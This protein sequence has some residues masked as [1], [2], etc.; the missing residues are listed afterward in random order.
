[1]AVWKQVLVAVVLLV[2]AAVGFV[3]FFP[4][5]QALL[6][7]WGL[8]GWGI[9]WAV[10]A[11]PNAEP[12]KAGAPAGEGARRPSTVVAAPVASATINDRL[13]AIGTGRANASVSIK[14]YSSGRLA[15]IVVQP[16]ARIA[17]GEIIARLDSDTE[18]IAVDRARF[19]MDDATA[20]AKRVKSLFSSN[21]ATTVQVTDADLAV[22]NA[23][24]ALGDAQLALERRVIT[25]P[26]GGIVGILPVEAGNYVDTGTEIARV[27]DRSS[28]IVDFYVP[29][30]YANAVEIGA[31]VS[32]TSIAR[33]KD[34]LEGKVSEIDNRLDDK[35]RT[36]LVR[37]RIA[38]A[39]D[40]LRAGMSF[41]VTM[42]FAGDTYPSVSPLAIQ[43][44][45]DGAF[46]WVVRDGT[47]RRTPVRIIQRNT[48]NVLV[49]GAL[50]ADE[51]VVTEGI[52]LVRDD[53]RILIAGQ[54]DA[55]RADGKP[56]A[57]SGS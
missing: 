19:A 36:L 7:G 38:N 11:V 53:A 32:A 34:A 4:G 43:W 26:I 27:E 2:L 10:A 55:E 44:G 9:D 37:A 5:A 40:T 48:E 49:D 47:A 18:V 42:R 31:A 12:D 16:G 21:A 54:A 28:I 20:R 52:H 6:A 33:P 30:R 23:R 1:M 56:A 15:A 45:T 35:S 29:E 14:P 39:D 25:S 50:A 3:R 8:A 24:L 13:A 22:E 41:E 46:V 57:G 17:K 51:Q